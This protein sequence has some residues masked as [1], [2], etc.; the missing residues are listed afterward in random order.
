MGLG[1]VQV[2]LKIQPKLRPYPTH[3]NFKQNY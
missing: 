2:L 1:Q 3:L